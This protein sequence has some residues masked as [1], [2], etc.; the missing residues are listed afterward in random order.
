MAGSQRKLMFPYKSQKRMSWN[1]YLDRRRR[2]QVNHLSTSLLTL[3]LLPTFVRT[4]E[5]YGGYPNIT[6]VASDVHYWAK[7]LPKEKI[8]S[9][10]SDPKFCTFSVMSDRY[11]VSKRKHPY[12]HATI[13][14]CISDPPC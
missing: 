13:S 1:A 14:E 12:R 6:I 7:P 10:L 5:K 9:T 3:L 4:A 2:I 11:N 8:L